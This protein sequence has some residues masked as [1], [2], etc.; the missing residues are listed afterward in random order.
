VG[1]FEMSRR[2]AQLANAVRRARRATAAPPIPDPLDGWPA[3]FER[4]DPYGPAPENRPAPVER[5]PLLLTRDPT[6]QMSFGERAALEGVLT[7]VRPRVAIEIGS[8]EGGSLR[9]LA[10]HAGRVHS[11]DV[12]HA[13]L[14][15]QVPANVTLHTGDSAEVLP[16]LLRAL[17]A[18]G[19]AVGLALVDGDH[20]Y[21]G[22]KRDLENLLTA[23]CTARSAIL[24]HDTMNAEVRAGVESVSLDQ[25]PGVVYYELDFVPGYVYRRGVARDMAWGGLG[26][27]L[28]DTERCGAYVISPRQDLYFE[29]FRAMYR[30]RSEARAQRAAGIAPPR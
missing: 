29:P 10:A 23:R 27:I 30:L 13:P 16:R 7:Q 15:G 1:S 8:A 17:T 5:G 19:E 20:S 22:V 9:R 18:D 6:W 14:A 12:D 4:N 28:L 3:R 2:G 26:L 24:V 21:D 11:I 25:H